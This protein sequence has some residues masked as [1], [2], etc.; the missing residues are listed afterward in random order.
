MDNKFFD[1]LKT[2]EVDIRAFLEA[3]YAWIQ[4]IVAKLGEETPEA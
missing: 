3:L 1:F 4:A 2:Y